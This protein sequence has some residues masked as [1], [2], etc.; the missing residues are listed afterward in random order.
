MFVKGLSALKQRPHLTSQTCL[1]QSE[2]LPQLSIS[3]ATAA[4][5]GQPWCFKSFWADIDTF[6]MLMQIHFFKLIQARW[7]S[8]CPLE[9]ADPPAVL[10]FFVEL[11]LFVEVV[12]NQGQEKV[13]SMLQYCWARM[14]CPHFFW[15][16]QHLYNQICE[17]REHGLA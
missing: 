5:W 8:K 11:F 6:F 16:L 17:H 7:A 12:E 10:F 15:R 3:I 4:L 13:E 2:F 9:S 1:S 14:E